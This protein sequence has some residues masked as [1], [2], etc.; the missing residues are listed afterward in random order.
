MRRCTTRSM[1]DT[2]AAIHY[3]GIIEKIFIHYIVVYYRRN[4]R[5]RL[6]RRI[7]IYHYRH[8][9]LHR[10]AAAYYR[11]GIP[12][13]NNANCRRINPNVRSHSIYINRHRQRQRRPPNR[14]SRQLAAHMLVVHR[15]IDQTVRIY[16]NCH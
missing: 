3:T 16:S 13:M 9:F 8:S 10:A 2:K 7:K 4:N 6:I 15:P 11:Y 14:V 1:S 12:A 5:R